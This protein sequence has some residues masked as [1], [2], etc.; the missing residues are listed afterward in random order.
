MLAIGVVAVAP[1]C[2]PAPHYSRLCVHQANDSLKQAG[3]QTL[4]DVVLASQ[5]L[6][7]LLSTDYL[8][9]LW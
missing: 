2:R 9:R 7:V 3:I 8:E 5:N 1:R 6:L 4:G